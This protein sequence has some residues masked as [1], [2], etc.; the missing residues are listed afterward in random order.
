MSCFKHKRSLDAY[1][2]V[3]S[4]SLAVNERHTFTRTDLVRT[5]WK[6][7]S[8]SKNKAVKKCQQSQI[9]LRLVINQCMIF[10]AGKNTDYVNSGIHA[11]C[12]H[13][14]HFCL[15]CHEGSS[16]V[17]YHDSCFINISNIIRKCKKPLLK[18]GF[19]AC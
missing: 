13:H 6:R 14:W 4:H 3:K 9:Y 10:S 18:N 7:C 17:S 19:K 11:A 1:K 8:Y 2:S 12:I 15:F 16:L 5:P